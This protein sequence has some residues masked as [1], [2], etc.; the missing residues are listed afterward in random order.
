MSR[1][2]LSVALMT[3]LLL[4]FLCGFCVSVAWGQSQPRITQ[5][6]DDSVVVRV[7]RTTHPLATRLNDRG[8]AAS[9][10]PMQRMMLV[11][12]PSD[13]Q[14]AAAA[15]LLDSQH[16]KNSANYQHWFS[17]EEYGKQFGPN[18]SDLNQI[19]IWL[20]QHGFQITSV[21]RGRQWIEFSGTAGQVE[22]AF[23][24][25]MHHYEVNGQKH[26]ANSSDIALPRAL[27]PVVS[28]VLSLHNFPKRSSQA[29]KIRVS[30]DPSTGK[31][32]PDFTFNTGSEVLHFL[33][34]GDYTRIYNT[35]PLLKAG[36][37]GSGVSIAIVGR[38]NINLSD[39][40][41]FRQIFQLPSKDP[42]II[43]NGPDP[44]INGDETEADLDVEWSGAVAP[45]ATIKF[46]T[47]EGTFSADGTDLSAA[48]IVDQRI[49]PIL[50]N[51]YGL[52]E[53]F[54]GTAGNV[55]F[56]NLYRQA[57]AEGI[58][59]FSAS[60]DSGAAGCD[61][62]GFTYAPSTLGAAVS[63][64]ASTPYNV[65]VG[66]TQF[67]ENG[68]DGTY[69]LAHNRPDQSSATGYI[70]EVVWNESCDPTVD[71]NQCF[72]SGLYFILGG[73]GGPSSCSSSTITDFVITCISGTPKPS[74]QAGIGVP[75]DGV[76]DIPDLSL[77]AAGHDAYIICVEGACQ[78]DQSGGQTVLNSF[79]AVDGTSASA[80]S[81][82]AI[83]ALLEQA[84]GQFQGQANYTFYQLA[85]A[86]NLAQCDSSNLTDPKQ[87]SSCVFY[88]TTAGNN[89]VPGVTGFT[90]GTGYDM[91]TGL[92]SVNAANLV[93]AWKV[94]PKLKSTTA[95]AVGSRSMQ[96]GQPLPLAVKVAPLIGTGSPSGDFSLITDKHGAT[97][98]GT[99]TNGTFAGTVSN[100]PGGF[101]NFSAY[102]AGDAMFG[103]S[104]SK[105]LPIRITPEE[106]VLSPVLYSALL[107][108]PLVPVADLDNKSQYGEPL[109]MQVDVKGKSGLGG[110]KGTATVSVDGKR[111]RT[112]DLTQQGTGL[113]WFQH[114][115]LHP[116]PHRF[117]VA[118][119]GDN[120]YQPSSVELPL[121]I[122]KG[123][124]D[125]VIDVA[126][127]VVNEGTPVKLFIVVFPAVLPT[128]A[129][130]P[131]GTVN[132]LDNGKV[133]ASGIKL[134]ENGIE[135]VVGQ[136]TYTLKLPAGGHDLK[137][138][139]SGDANYLARLWQSHDNFVTV[140][141]NTGGSVKVTMQ[142]SPSEISVGASVRYDITVRPTKS[143]GPVPTGTVGMVSLD[144]FVQEDPI[145]LVN[146]NASFVVPYYASGLNLNSANY[147]GDANYNAANSPNMM[148]T[149]NQLV[150]TVTLTSS[151]QSTADG[152]TVDLTV[153]VV[154]RPNNPNLQ[155]PAGAVQLYDSVDG[156]REF[157]IGDLQRLT[158]GNGQTAIYTWGAALRRGTNVLRVQYLGSETSFV[159]P[160]LNDWAP[161]SSNQVMVV[162]K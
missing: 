146:G 53:A 94:A 75:D 104:S 95:L 131:S 116:G 13:S 50:S 80:P 7:P 118:Y 103:S 132:I 70:P 156:G 27:A 111:F 139:Y 25:E 136:A 3:S 32:V 97:F 34:P 113:D 87:S 10:L 149:V 108:G 71:P 82:A 127:A 58:T 151:I 105:S 26:V 115:D 30:R 112:I 9:D 83:M 31:L 100:L 74:W 39:I 42:E 15:K 54:L 120:S 157:K 20:Q 85:A 141:P 64:L 147:S 96:H 38:T 60:G 24:T 40:Q 37:D 29:R 93:S 145:P 160:N 102:Y 159:T 44:G 142:Q 88:D 123:Y 98:G 61:F 76:R 106:S 130:P 117:T 23:R 17:P 1:R 78:T 150:P 49:A 162:V 21:P 11:L 51:S 137:L 91:G 153:L 45:A 92:G 36:I 47:S 12:Q 152:A 5:A 68:H 8:R 57:A 62:A 144:G 138:I 155:L 52:C 122:T 148:T 161:A 16:D 2:S 119:S 19:S 33:T 114:L 84:N 65:A 41:T 128:P 28:G 154:G 77:A 133:L 110:A 59:V 121:K 72:G 48:Y 35:Q 90:A 56:N 101:Y 18:Q 126:P 129:K 6:I 140:N 107:E 22:R 73:G 46:V 4:V 135:G 124:A 79:F 158:V 125:G 67:N 143:G 66:G 14:R 55:F 99:L 89:G 109:F 86:E 63:G 134:A 69:W 43:L 81:M